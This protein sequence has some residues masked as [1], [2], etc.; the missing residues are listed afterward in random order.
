ML[1]PAELSHQLP[2]IYIFKQANAKLREKD[3]LESTRAGG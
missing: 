3:N 1:L 2:N